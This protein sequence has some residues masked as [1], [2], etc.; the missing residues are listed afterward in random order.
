MME[1][2]AGNYLM[3][4]T[5]LGLGY[6]IYSNSSSKDDESGSGD[7]NTNQTSAN[8]KF[9]NTS[10][11]GI[12]ERQL[13]KDTFTTSCGFSPTEEGCEDFNTKMEGD[14][15]EDC[16]SLMKRSKMY[17]ELFNYGYK[18]ECQ[19]CCDKP[20]MESLC[21]LD[22]EVSVVGKGGH[23]LRV[24]VSRDSPM[25]YANQTG[26]FYV[27]LQAFTNCHKKKNAL[28]GWAYSHFGRID[29]GSEKSFRD[30]EFLEVTLANP[31]GDVLVADAGLEI[32]ADDDYVNIT[33][34]SDCM[35]T[36]DAPHGYGYNSSTKC[37]GF[38]QF[39]FKI[40]PQDT[41]VPEEMIGAFDLSMK[42]RVLRPDNWTGGCGF[43]ET[44]EITV[45]N[46]IFI[47]PTKCK[48][49]CKTLGSANSED[50]YEYVVS[51]G[52]QLAIA[53]YW[54]EI[55]AWIR[56]AQRNKTDYDTWNEQFLSETLT[57]PSKPLS[58]ISRNSYIS[59]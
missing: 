39:T 56:E 13:F 21:L 38:S 19:D 57:T 33:N 45:P 26:E 30:L 20:S 29:S 9:A 42:V 7:D 28:D 12:A 16:Y 18:S 51:Q 55:P 35:I 8:N 44:Y 48:N 17:N 14:C 31:S 58:L 46:V 15:D 6:L 25:M 47:L 40:K 49:N 43:D 59:Y 53:N 10:K 27:N 5:V 3:F 36:D 1:L 54:N 22:G 11:G 50:Y 52:R 32:P 2:S 34:K 24:W 37:G 23:A 4:G 41:E